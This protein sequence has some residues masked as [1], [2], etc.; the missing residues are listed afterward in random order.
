MSIVPLVRVLAIEFGPCK[1]KLAKSCKTIPSKQNYKVL[2]AFS[3]F[4]TE[5]EMR[6]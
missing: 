1:W 6:C 5:S 2:S 3:P 4:L